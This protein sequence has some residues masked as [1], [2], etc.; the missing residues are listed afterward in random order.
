[1]NSV[2]I[3]LLQ[4]SDPNS[5]FFTFLHDD[6]FQCYLRS[7]RSFSTC[8]ICYPRASLLLLLHFH[9]VLPQLL[10]RHL[11]LKTQTSPSP[12]FLHPPASL[13]SSK[14]RLVPSKY[15]SLISSRIAAPLLFQLLM[16]HLFLKTQISPSPAFLH[17]PAS[18]A[19]SKTRRLPSLISFPNTLHSFIIRLR[20]KEC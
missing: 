19:S 17:P 3:S 13:A 20:M 14:A 4:G 11:L 6:N 9:Q 8:K 1:M 2:K 18:L 7:L 10:M 16:R 5:K 15:R 12:A